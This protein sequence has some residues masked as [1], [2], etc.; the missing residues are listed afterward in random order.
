MKNI[1][2]IVLDSFSFREFEKDHGKNMPFINELLKKS[3]WA[4]VYA[5]GPHTEIGTHGLTGSTN[6]LDYGGTLTFC[7]KCPKVIYDYFLENGYDVHCI[8]DPQVPAPLRLFKNKKY[9]QYYRRPVTFEDC[10]SNRMEF[11]SNIALHRELD[12]RERNTVEDF[13]EYWIE[14]VM[15]FYDCKNGNKDYSL[16]S[17]EIEHIDFDYILQICKDEKEKFIRNKKEYIDYLLQNK[18]KNRLF[19]LVDYE[20]DK[21]FDKDFVDFVSKKYRNIYKELRLKTISANLFY[22]VDF[23]NIVRGIPGYLQRKFLGKQGANY[24]IGNYITRLT[25]YKQYLNKDDPNNTKGFYLPSLKRQFMKIYDIFDC[26]INNN[27]P[28]FVYVRPE[29][30]HFFNNWYSLDINDKKNI[31]KE[32]DDAKEILSSIS[33]KE[34]E[35]IGYKLAAKYVDSCIKEL[36]GELKKRN[37]LD[38]TNIIITS[39]HGSS[40]GSYPIRNAAMVLNWFSENYHI[41]FIYYGENQCKKSFGL[42]ENIDI[43]PTVLESLGITYGEELSGISFWNGNNRI[44]AHSEYTGPGASDLFLK[45]FWFIARNYKYS[46]YYTVNIYQSFGEGKLHAVYD[47]KKDYLETKNIA[48]DINLAEIA[49]LLDFIETRFKK[50]QSD[51]GIIIS[52]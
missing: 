3:F 17:R 52:C 11:F 14:N 26:Y 43:L 41:P 13:F 31:D 19:G 16:I 48:P 10:W 35:N 51:N 15:E 18:G 29:E 45:D 44:I 32:M 23:W 25:S 39:D 21:E 40:F 36:F 33:G 7:E 24:Y 4:E 1:I 9:Y 42:H 49:D 50:I 20:Y 5:Q 28:F 38:N 2:F 34:S 37:L 30:L 22:D 8:D 6:T 27:N 47:I 46:I 12:T